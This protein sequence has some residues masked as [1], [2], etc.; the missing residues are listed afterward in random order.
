[1]ASRALQDAVAEVAVVAALVPL[2]RAVVNFRKL[3][4]GEALV[5]AGAKAV[6]A[7]EA[8]ETRSAWSSGAR[9]GFF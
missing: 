3:E 1:M 7:E 9:R 5:V 4:Q 2:R 6:T 8:A